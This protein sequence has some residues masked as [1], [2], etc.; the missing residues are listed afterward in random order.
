MNNL[1]INRKAELSYLKQWLGQERKESKI[2]L[3]R[4]PTGVGKTDLV[5][6]AV[7]E[8]TVPVIRVQ[9][10]DHPDFTA[11]DGEYLL[12][13]FRS[14]AQQSIRDDRILGI[15]TFLLLR[16]GDQT[17]LKAAGAAAKHFA[18]NFGKKYLG[19]DGVRAVKDILSTDVK[20]LRQLS[21]G[22]PEIIRDEIISYTVA[23]LSSV[24]CIIQIENI[25]KI[26]RTSLEF[27][28][29]FFSQC[30]GLKGIFEYT[31]MTENFLSCEAIQATLESENVECMIYE[32]QPIPVE[33]LLQGL[34][35]RP[36]VFRTAL[37]R[38]Y[39]EQG[40]N[41]RVI[42]DV[43][44]LATSLATNSDVREPKGQ[45]PLGERAI[46]SLPNAQRLLLGLLVVHGGEADSEIIGAAIATQQEH[47]PSVGAGLDFMRD[48]RELCSVKYLVS[49][50]KKTRI[51]HDSVTTTFLNDPSN[52]KFILLAREAW[53]HFYRDVVEHDDPFLKTDALYWLPVLYLGSDKTEQ[54]VAVLEQHGRAALRSFAPRRLASIFQHI[55]NLTSQVATAVL[56]GRLDALI[57]QQ[58]SVL[59]DSCLL[60][61]ACECLEQAGQ[62]SLAGRLIY[63]DACVATDR[64]DTGMAMIKALEHEYRETTPHSRH[65]RMRTG[66]VKI[67]AYRTGGQLEA[68]E[69]LFRELL[70][71][72]DLH[73]LPVYASLLRCADVGLYKDSDTEECIALLEQ[74]VKLCLQ[75][76]LPADEA[77]AHI[78]LC[79]HFGY[80]GDLERAQQELSAADALSQ[81]VW[82]ERYSIINNQAV[83]DIMAGQKIGAEAA[84]KKALMLATEDGDRLL[85]LC[86]Y[87][88][89]G[90][91]PVA[92]ELARLLDEIID[93]SEELAKIAHYNLSVFYAGEGDSIQSD[94]HR[95]EAAAMADTM[96]EEFWACALRGQ[97]SLSPSTAHRLHAGYY[98]V[99]IVHWRLTS[100][101]FQS[102]SH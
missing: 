49:E 13:L 67:H 37:T 19:D 5:R 47:M 70:T 39:Q 32:L 92:E 83:L 80:R 40:F 6:H 55:R 97:N 91:H 31:K 18:L 69:S 16:N 22:R 88:A 96:D 43:N 52:K 73:H 15:E 63:A 98:L 46:R 75:H 36:D 2:L 12:R 25:Q 4:A 81:R 14:L 42:V 90:S 33:E 65:V 62:L 8:A 26:D 77:A 101:T 85:L 99:F 68:A 78:A 71:W 57:E 48:I 20:R 59:F 95:S 44:I 53:E 58:A 84:F 100:V 38:H 89:V 61:E 51:A 102:I 87:L 28:N 93:P 50:G 34:K 11:D 82:I 56:P 86:N 64:F 45:E 7:Q 24:H 76:D 66:L 79:Q 10:V 21:E 23:V 35:D 1:F 27:F 29:T 60:N 72:E 3:M 94:F 41:L 30:T 9:V 54:L 74:A 17:A